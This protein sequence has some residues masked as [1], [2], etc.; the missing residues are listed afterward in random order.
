[1][2]KTSSR[3]NWGKPA[4]SKRPSWPRDLLCT[5][6]ILSFIRLSSTTSITSVDLRMVNCA[7][8]KSGWVITEKMRFMMRHGTSWNS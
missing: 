1:M 8:S 2:S 3:T 6:D 4:C 5:T 7:M